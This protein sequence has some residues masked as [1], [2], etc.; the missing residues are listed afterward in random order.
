MEDRVEVLREA[1]HTIAIEAIAASLEALR[2]AT[3][4]VEAS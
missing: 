3:T 4:S 2:R 1:H